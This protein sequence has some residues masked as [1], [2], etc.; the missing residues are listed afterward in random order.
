M[1]PTTEGRGLRQRAAEDSGVQLSSCG[2]LIQHWGK[3]KP[4]RWKSDVGC[5]KLI[6]NMAQ[7][8]S[9]EFIAQK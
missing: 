9:Q 1:S 8:W 2:G 6:K 5:A 4:V 3:A 7:I